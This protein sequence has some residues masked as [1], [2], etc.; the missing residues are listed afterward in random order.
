M[1]RN[2]GVKAEKRPK[3][4]R[5][6]V[7]G[8]RGSA[9]WFGPTAQRIKNWRDTSM[10][11]IAHTARIMAML[12]VV[13]LST[14]GTAAQTEMG[15]VNPP[16]RHD[17]VLT[18][19]GPA[20]A[21]SPRQQPAVPT[22]GATRDEPSPPAV[23]PRPPAKALAGPKFLDLRY[24]EDFSY[25]DGERGSYK[26]DFFDP[27]K[28]IDLGDG[29]HLTL[30]GEFR[31]RLEAED[32]FAFASRRKSQDTFQ[33]YRYMLHADLRYQDRFRVFLQG[34]SLHDEDRDLPD[35]PFDENELALQQ[36]FVDVRPFGDNT[37]LLIRFGRQ[38]LMYGA[39]RFVSPLRWVN[40][41]RRFDAVKLVYQAP[42]WQF[43]VFYAKP[44][45]PIRR[46]EFDIYNEEFDFYGAYWTYRGIPNHGVDVFFFAN[47]DT[48][49]RTNPNGRSGDVTRFT[50]GGRFHGKRSGFD[51]DAMLAG[52]WGRWAGDSIR[53]WAWTLD[54]GYTI[55]ALKYKPRIGAG[56]D[57]ASGDRN[58]T[59]RTV[60]T[61]DQLFPLGHKYLGFM[62]FFGR[63]NIQS[64]NVNVSAWPIPKKVKARLAYLA[65]WLESKD[66]AIYNVGGAPGRRDP[67]GQSGREI[68]HEIDLTVLWKVDPHQSLL[69]GY[70]HFFDSDVIINTG[71]SEDADFFYVQYSFKF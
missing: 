53:A 22:P 63:Q 39:E 60:Q 62:D 33:L 71:P 28:Y 68:G 49:N 27:I 5:S 64:V 23:S 70:S 17:A 59:D 55:G 6:T 65:F 15:E 38:D 16:A 14:E 11:R 25:L 57:W 29:W 18:S 21:P 44:V 2:N 67:T 66:D 41:R 19:P 58:P 61:F 7:D 43:D 34:A 56:F 10:K 47:D 36:L 48:Q 4:A 8:P 42:K 40:S 1:V 13:G 52:Q 26:T 46:A 45:L 51:Y 20:D 32:N 3:I 30:G 54:G 31:F 50:L 24:D 9:V 12:L 37:P 35:R 69:L